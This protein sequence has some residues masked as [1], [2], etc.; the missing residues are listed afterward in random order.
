MHGPSSQE[1]DS[2]LWAEDDL[3]S[4]SPPSHHIQEPLEGHRALRQQGDIIRV[5][6][7][8]REI[9][10]ALDPRARE[11]GHEV[12]WARLHMSLDLSRQVLKEENA[13]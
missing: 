13:Q 7:H 1:A 11:E 3:P 12:A 4:L 10:M 5:Q 2:A 6:Q 9:G 8:D